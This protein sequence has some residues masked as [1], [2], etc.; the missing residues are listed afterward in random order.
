MTCQQPW[1]TRE[2]AAVT[3][4]G[5][6]SSLVREKDMTQ[7]QFVLYILSLQRWKDIFMSQ[8]LTKSVIPTYNSV[9]ALHNATALRLQ[10]V[11]AYIRY[12]TAVH[13]GVEARIAEVAGTEPSQTMMYNSGMSAVMSAV[14]AG[15]ALANCENPKI[16]YA[17]ELYAGTTRWLKAYTKRNNIDFCTFDSG[18]SQDIQKVISEFQPDIIL[19]ETIGNYASMPVLDHDALLQF[20]RAQPNQPLVVIDNTLPLSTAC[21]IYDAIKATDNVVVVESGTKAY[22]FN[23]EMLGISYTKNTQVL[24]AMRAARNEGSLPGVGTA[25]YIDELL[26]TKESFHERNQ[27]I[28]DKTLD[29]ANQLKA[30]A[31]G[32]TVNHPG[33]AS[34]PVLF[35]KPHTQSLTDALQFAEQI[36]N[37]LEVQK[38]VTIGDSFGFDQTSFYSGKDIDFIRIAPGAEADIDALA[39]AIK[40]SLNLK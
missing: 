14:E 21:P 13:S 6:P 36:G 28:F 31:S 40:Q 29:L 23:V 33:T 17:K 22:T 10:G 4:E 35:I 11:S 5:A 24:Q 7:K 34:V 32:F 8:T 1:V 39:Q 3:H 15:R 12:G 27:R 26:P 19:V 25:R 2:K 18:D 16:A 9:S 30:C 38:H 37:D 20:V